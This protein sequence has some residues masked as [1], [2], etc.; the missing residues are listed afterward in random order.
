MAVLQ[1]EQCS[2]RPQGKCPLYL[3]PFPVWSHCARRANMIQWKKTHFSCF[4][5]RLQQIIWLI[6]TEASLQQFQTVNKSSHYGIA[7]KYLLWIIWRLTSN[8]I[9]NNG[10]I[11]WL[12]TFSNVKPFERN[13]PSTK[14]A[15]QAHQLCNSMYRSMYANRNRI[16]RGHQMKE[17]KNKSYWCRIKLC[18]III[19]WD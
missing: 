16:H 19:T 10:F 5:S 2:E 1:C 3:N 8:D 7:Y 18:G 12:A 17:T 13:I 4:L 11:L 6:Y 14:P 15:L 9:C